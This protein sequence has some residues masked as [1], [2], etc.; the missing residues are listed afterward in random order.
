MYAEITQNRTQL[1]EFYLP[2]Y[3]VVEKI[4]ESRT[5]PTTCHGS[6]RQTA[7]A[8]L[9]NFSETGKTNQTPI[10]NIIL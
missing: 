1:V 9:N 3:P 7:V 10:W 5:V 2:G 8:F 4:F 6:A